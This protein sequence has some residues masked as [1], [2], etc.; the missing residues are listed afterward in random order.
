MIHLPWE[1]EGEGEVLGEVDFMGQK[2][3]LGRC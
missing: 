3:R 2:G 1:K